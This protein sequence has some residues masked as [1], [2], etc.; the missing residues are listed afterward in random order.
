MGGLKMKAL[1]IAVYLAIALAVF[2]GCGARDFSAG[3]TVTVSVDKDGNCQASYTSN[4]EQQGLEAM[5]CGGGVKV[6]RSGTLESVV[7]ASV[8]ANL[9]LLEILAQLL[10][11]IPAAGKIASTTGS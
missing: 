2:F 8:S 10:Q 9:K 5:I 4:K 1:F 3:T 7:A 11:M 6:D